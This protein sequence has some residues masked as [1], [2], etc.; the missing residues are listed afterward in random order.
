MRQALTRFM[1]DESGTETLEWGMVCGLIVILAI[2][3]LIAIGPKISK[4]W[5]DTTT[6]MN[7]L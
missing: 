4:L 7:K 6:E 2:T 3:A 5:T 1:R